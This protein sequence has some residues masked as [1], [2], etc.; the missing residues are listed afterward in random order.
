MD[1]LSSNREVILGTASNRAFGVNASELLTSREVILV[2]DST[3]RI[4]HL[5]DLYLRVMR[6]EDFKL[7][8]TDNKSQVRAQNELNNIQRAL[9]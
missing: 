7:T 9:R 8:Y 2:S 4:D 1:A 3:A 6:L 5:T